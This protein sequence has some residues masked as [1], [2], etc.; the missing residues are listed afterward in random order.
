MIH[1]LFICVFKINLVKIN[2]LSDSIQKN[3]MEYVFFFS[4]EDYFKC[5]TCQSIITT[6]I[7]K[8]FI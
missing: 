4:N 8:N 2:Y 5:D 7:S 3:I 1:I 6:T